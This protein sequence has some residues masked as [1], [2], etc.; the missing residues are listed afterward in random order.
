MLT[1]LHIFLLKYSLLQTIIEEFLL[2]KLIKR[3]NYTR[4][5]RNITRHKTTI[6]Q[7]QNKHKQQQHK[8]RKTQKQEQQTTT[9]YI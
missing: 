2:I 4:R 1:T 7:Q 3:H 8:H 5:T 6:K 9:T